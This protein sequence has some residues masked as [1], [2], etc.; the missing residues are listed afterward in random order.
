MRRKNK[1]NLV[2]IAVFIIILILFYIFSP[3]F[4]STLANYGI[5]GQSDDSSFAAVTETGALMH[6]IDVGQGDS[7]LLQSGEY[8]ILV[9]AGPNSAEDELISY[10]NSAGVDRLDCLVLTHPHEDHI[11]GADLVIDTFDIDTVLMPDCTATTKAFENVLDAMEEKGLGVTVPERGDNFSLGKLD[12]TV[13][14]P[15]GNDYDETNDF[16]IVLKVEYENTS[17]M[18]T[19][20]AETLS[21]QE[22]LDKFDSDFLKC[23]VLKAGHHGSSTSSCEDFVLAVAPRYAAVSCALDNNYGHPHKETRTLFDELGIEWYRTDYDGNIV[24]VSDGENVG[25]K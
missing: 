14:A 1:I 10:L 15:A 24:F 21:E 9:D 13:L 11:G 23:D 8:N 16:S 6:V 17:F 5:F 22:I 25:V 7:I 20:D 12:F 18:L 2:S 19:G 3:E 4:R